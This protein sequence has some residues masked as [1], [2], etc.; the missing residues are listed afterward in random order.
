MAR[1]IVSANS[2]W[3]LQHFRGSLI[4]ELIRHGH[5]IITISPDPSGVEID[6]VKFPHR[7]CKMV[8]SGMNPIQDVGYFSGLLRILLEEKPNFFLG[9]TI[10]PNIYGCI[11][12]RLCRIPAVPNVSGLG[13]AFLGAS[14]LKRVALGMYRFAFRRA[15]SVFFQNAADQSLFVAKGIVRPDR[16][17]VLPGSGI[18]LDRFRMSGVPAGL[19]FLMI[20]RLLGDK[21]VREYVEA[22][23]RFRRTNPNATFRLLGDMDP[24]NRTGIAK[25]ELDGWISEGIIEYLGSTSDVREHIRDASA[26]VLPSYREGLARTLLEGAAMGRPLIATSVPGCREVV[27]EAETGFL[28]EPRSVT[29]LVA[30]LD[31]FAEISTDE[32]SRMGI[33]ARTMAEEEFREELVFRNYLEVIEN[34]G[35]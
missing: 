26:I 2:T 33:R 15:T 24:H 23:R 14:H 35:R 17:R 7:S 1:I 28:C 30:A 32:R 25:S 5:E 18:D 8:R 20:A 34:D 13:T 9:F 4:K 16:T 21:G 3:N 11:A 6:G 29:S 27:R 12:S 10:K 19:T 22:A 31:R